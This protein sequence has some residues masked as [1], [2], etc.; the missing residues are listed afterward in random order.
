MLGDTGEYNLVRL[1]VMRAPNCAT[2]PRLDLLIVHYGGDN[3]KGDFPF[4]FCDFHRRRPT[5]RSSRRRN[6]AGVSYFGLPADKPDSTL[7]HIQ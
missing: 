1:P 6:L 2:G 7:R 5:Q 4:Q 3:G